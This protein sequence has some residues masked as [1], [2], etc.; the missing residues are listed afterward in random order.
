MAK[1]ILLIL[2]K[3]LLF[4][5]KLAVLIIAFLLKGA[6][7][8]LS[9]LLVFVSVASGMIYIAISVFATIFAVSGT[10]VV[11]GWIQNG[12]FPLLD[13]CVVIGILWLFA[14]STYI[15]STLGETIADWFESDFM[16]QQ[17]LN[18]Y[19]I[20]LKY[21]RNLSQKD[22]NVMSTSPQIHK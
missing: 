2:L 3:V 5:V 22:S 8:L 15:I 13:G 9:Y 10:V 16:K 6:F 12:T 17:R 4:P 18:F 14:M 11:V 21:V 19:S 20:D 1:V 7:Y